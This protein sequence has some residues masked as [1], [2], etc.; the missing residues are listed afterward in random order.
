LP[1]LS[2]CDAVVASAEEHEVGEVGAAAVLPG[3]EV[4]G[5]AVSWWSVA[6]GVGASAVAGVEGSAEA[7]S[8]GA[9]GSAGVDRQ[10]EVVEH[11][12]GDAGVAEQ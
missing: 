1:A 11:G 4:V 7:W 3:D 6:S 9:C 12:G 5:V 10:A 2:V 8:G